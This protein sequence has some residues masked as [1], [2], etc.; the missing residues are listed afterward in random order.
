MK[1]VPFLVS[2][3]LAFLCV[4]LSFISFSGGQTSNALQSVLL[5][6]QTEIQELSQKFQIQQADYQRQTQTINTTKAVVEKA[7]P[8]L[9]NAGYVAAKNKNEKLKNLLIQ[10]KWKDFIP[11]DEKLKEIEDAIKKQGQP[12]TGAAPSNPPGTGAVPLRGAPSAAP[13]P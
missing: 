9:Q 6:K 3:A 5:T 7:L 1:T 8:V 11:T 12:A 13:A 2:S 10:Q 4:I